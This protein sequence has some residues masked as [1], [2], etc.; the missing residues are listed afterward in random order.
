MTLCLAGTRC[1]SLYERRFADLAATLP[2]AVYA[3]GRGAASSCPREFGYWVAGPRNLEI[4]YSSAAIDEIR[5]QAAEGYQ[6]MRHGGVEVGGVLFG[7]HAGRTVRILAMRP[8]E[9]GYSNGPRFILSELDETA[10]ANLLKNSAGD[11]ELADMEPVGWY[12]S[13]TRE[14]ITAT[15]LPMCGS[16]IASSRRP[17]RWRWWCVPPT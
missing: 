13:H 1:R 6:R 9:C 14:E 7:T 12:H 2:K 15:P 4:E 17:G 3:V 11:P 8:I 10:L 16:S 5:M